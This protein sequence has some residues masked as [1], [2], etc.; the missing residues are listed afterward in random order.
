MTLS[1]STVAIIGTGTLGS[2]LAA[3]F[4]AGARTS[5]WPDGTRRPPENSRPALTATP[6]WSAWT[7]PSTGPT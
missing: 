5:C 2:T 6:K 7:R 4:A 1:D 3:N